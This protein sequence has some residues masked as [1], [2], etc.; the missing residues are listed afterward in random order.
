MVIYRPSDKIPVKIGDLTLLISPLSAEQN[1]MILSLTRMKGG[2]EVADA[3]R[4]A[5]VTLKYCVKEVQGLNGA[6][7]AD[8]SPVSFDFDENGILTDDSITVLYGLLNTATLNLLAAKLATE[9]IKK[10]DIPG[11]SFELDKVITSKKKV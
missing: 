1:A 10:H 6:T 3:A 11:V 2:E 5:L 9:G 8:G 7:F 4:M